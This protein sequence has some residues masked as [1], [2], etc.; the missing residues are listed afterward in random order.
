MV[1]LGELGERKII[2]SIIGPVVP[3]MGD[4]CAVVTRSD[5]DFLVTTDPVPIPAAKV[6]GG[7]EDYYW[8]GWLLVTIN[9][10]DLAAAGAT[11]IGFVSAIEAPGE[12][13]VEEFTR[14]VAGTVDACRAEGLPY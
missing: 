8:M 4:D 6:I 7:D 11:P 14:L 3:G 13:D 1:T 2:R 9:A 12:M 5:G 10:S